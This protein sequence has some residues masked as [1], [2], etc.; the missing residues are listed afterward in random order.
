VS[1]K[2]LDFACSAEWELPVFDQVNLYWGVINE[3]H[4][5]ILPAYDLR[6]NNVSC[7]GAIPHALLD[8][9]EQ[10][11][12]EFDC[13]RLRYYATTVPEKSCGR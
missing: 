5:V 12:N 7:D 10:Q 4:K 9:E 2:V 8:L 3:T 11:E 6:Q 1:I 13:S